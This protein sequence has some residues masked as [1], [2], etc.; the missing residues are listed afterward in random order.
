LFRLSSTAFWNAAS[1]FWYS[2]LV[3]QQL[4]QEQ[5]VVAVVGGLCNLFVHPCD[6]LSDVQ[7]LLLENRLDQASKVNDELLKQSPND[8]EGLLYRGQILVRQGRASDAITVSESA[9]RKDPNNYQVYCC[10]G[11]AYSQLG[12]LD[13]AEN[14][15]REGVRLRPRAIDAQQEL[16]SIALRRG[17]FDQLA[18][19]AGALIQLLPT[20]P[21]GYSD[22]GIVKA[23]R[24][25]LH[26][27]G[28]HWD[29]FER[30]VSLPAPT[31][32]PCPAVSGTSTS[33]L[34]S[35]AARCS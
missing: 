20:S 14:E 25:D 1:A 2:F 13:L 31:A 18:N 9:L 27:L 22:R 19:S 28:N 21:L 17:N 33:V 24:N 4:T 11:F 6:G 10:L 3:C 16:A 35:C 8:L 29:P 15:W 12:K 26:V 7:P 34:A 5:V 23:S 32:P 30:P